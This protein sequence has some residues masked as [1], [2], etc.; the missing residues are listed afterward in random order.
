MYSDSREEGM[1][2]LYLRKLQT[3][4]GKTDDAD[5][6]TTNTMYV[7]IHHARDWRI[8]RK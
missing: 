3:P 2:M 4:D 1:A 7:R 8:E 5:S 6:T